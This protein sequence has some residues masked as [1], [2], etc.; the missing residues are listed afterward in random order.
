MNDAYYQQ[1]LAKFVQSLPASSVRFLHFGKDF[2]GNWKPGINSVVKE[3]A[4]HG[5]NYPQSFYISPGFTP[6]FCYVQRESEVKYDVSLS[7]QNNVI[8]FNE[9]KFIPQS[10]IQIGGDNIQANWGDHF[11]IGI[12]RDFDTQKLFYKIHKTRYGY[13]STIQQYRNIATHCDVLFDKD[14]TKFHD[15]LKC[16]SLGAPL[17]RTLS[18]FKVGMKDKYAFLMLQALLQKIVKPVSRSGAYITHRG[19]RYKVH[20]GP[21]GVRY[22]MVNR[23]KKYINPVPMRGGYSMYTPDGFVD[24]FAQFLIDYLITKIATKIPRL[25]EVMYYDDDG[26]DRVMVRYVQDL[27]EFNNEILRSNAY[28]MTKSYVLDTYHIYLTSPERRTETATKQLDNFAINA[29]QVVVEAHA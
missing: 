1:N 11:T 8:A 15:K 23:K 26:S 16:Y 14:V 6:N 9:T 7:K 29:H 2:Y 19:K 4:N 10:N 17:D 24:S 28:A 3:W 12:E 5:T 25:R 13:D 27:G 18:W 20:E 22:I 21:Q